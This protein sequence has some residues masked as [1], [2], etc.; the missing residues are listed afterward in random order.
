M[1]NKGSGNN[2]KIMSGLFWTFGERITAQLVSTLVTIIL[3]RILD[4]EHY[5]IISMVTVFISVCNVFVSSGFGSSLVQKKEA[6]ELDFDTALILSLLL[7]ILLYFLLFLIAPLIAKFY[8]M[9]ELTVIIRIMGIRLPIAAINCIQQAYI[10]RKME[11]RKFFISTIFGTI[12]SG[13]VGIVMAYLNFGVWALIGQYLTNTTVDTIVLAFNS[14]WTPHLRFSIRKAKEIFTFGWKVLATDLVYTLEGD[15]RSLII[16]KAFGTSELAYYDQGRKYPSLLVTNINTSINKVMLPA[17]SEYQDNLE[18][19]NGLLRKSVNIC[20]YIICP[21]LL[22]FA[23]V[24]HDF[25]SVVLGEK[26]LSC[27][28]IIQIMCL[29]LLTRPLQ[30]SCQQAIL[31]IGRSEVV[32]Y[33]MAIINVISFSSLL[34]FTFVYHSIILITIGLLISDIVGL[35]CFMIA[36]RALLEYKLID[37]IKD[38]VPVLVMCVLMILVLLPIGKIDLSMGLSLTCKIICGGIT[39]FLLSLII[40]PPAFLYVKQLVLSTI[41]KVKK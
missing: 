21:M 7:S 5:G 11:F 18:S 24:S 30:T 28:P 3:A 22:G 35:I 19:L 17:Y 39:Y 23:L 36:S 8:V 37:Q 15:I 27:V 33:I 26:W 25:I 4:P 32:L 12:L 10:R 1:E 16:G 13:V 40:K 29:A 14:G 20:I 41:S 31:A 6:D 9:E 34:L 2:K 38:I